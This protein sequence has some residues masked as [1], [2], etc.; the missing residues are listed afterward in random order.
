MAVEEHN[1]QSRSVV[2]AQR[3]TPIARPSRPLEP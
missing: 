1:G 2:V 3:L